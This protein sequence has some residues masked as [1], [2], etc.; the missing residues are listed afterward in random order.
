MV[1]SGSVGGNYIE[2]VNG[3]V[4]SC[5]IGI[6]RKINQNTITESHIDVYDSDTSDIEL[7]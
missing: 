3:K 2:L 6:L 5:V 4:I 1:F 7:E